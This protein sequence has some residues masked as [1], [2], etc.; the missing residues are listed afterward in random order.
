MLRIVL[1]DIEGTTSA[2]SFVKEL[3]FP[4]AARTLPAFLRENAGEPAVAA[5]LAA[6]RREEKLAD[7][8]LEGAIAALLRWIDEDK[9][10][11]PLKTLQGMVWKQGFESGAFRSHLY[12]D[13]HEALVRWH[14]EGIALYVYSSGSVE[15]QK[16]LFKHTEYG[17]LTPLLRGYFDTVTGPK[18]EVS[19]YERIAEALHVK[20]AEVL[21]LSDV[22]EELDAASQ[23][24][25]AVRQLV[26]QEDYP[27][28]S[29][30]DARHPAVASFAEL[31][32][33]NIGR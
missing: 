24:G 33:L 16:L 19:S 6:V 2:I 28:A 12:V 8:D 23:A 14:A 4:Y 9:K 7:G 15:A 30:S 32:P 25:M 11:T 31:D 27:G 22:P 5:E 29:V 21:F 13:A 18:R 26:R 17:D 1:T 20:P 10:A 3:L